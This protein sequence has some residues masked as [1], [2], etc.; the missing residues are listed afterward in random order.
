M[1]PLEELLWRLEAD[2]VGLF[3]PQRFSGAL[4]VPM[5]N[6]FLLLFVVLVLQGH[7][8]AQ[9]LVLWVATQREGSASPVPLAP[10]TAKVL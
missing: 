2:G 1:L 7:G 4:K 6:L 8:P 5:M 10:K 3:P 9:D